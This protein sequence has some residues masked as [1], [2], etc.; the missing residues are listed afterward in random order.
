[1]GYVYK[2]VN[3]ING[4]WYI[5]SHNGNDKYYRTGGKA[6]KL[7]IKKYGHDNFDRYI[8]YRGD[9]YTLVEELS[10][11]SHD[12][13]NDPMSYNL[14][15]L[16]K[17]TCSR[18]DLARMNVERGHSCEINGVKYSSKVE[19]AIALGCS[20]SRIS[21]ILKSGADTWVRQRKKRK[22]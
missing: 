3:K 14:S 22:K 15:N 17:G 7:A 10:L 1:M 9:D 18:P 12:A 5:G 6:M 16:A 2:Y 13:A 8:I 20:K 21:E 19:A 11:K 4:K